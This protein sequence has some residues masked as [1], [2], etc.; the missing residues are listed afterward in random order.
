MDNAFAQTVQNA[1]TAAHATSPVS[2]FG[3]Y[4]FFVPFLAIVGLFY[5]LMI[6]PQ[7]KEQQ[8][9]DDMLKAIQRGDRVLTRGGLYGTVADIKDQV[10]ILKIN[11]NNKVEVHRDYVETVQKPS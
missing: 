3:S 6:Y 2:P 4:S 1:T 9:R 5:F 11:E 8:K 7:K 10:L